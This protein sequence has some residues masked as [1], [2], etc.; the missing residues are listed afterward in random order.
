MAESSQNLV[1]V[2]T[3]SGTRRDPMVALRHCV[4]EIVSD[5]SHKVF[6]ARAYIF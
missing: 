4:L 5:Q 6:S 2:C 1:S 3:G